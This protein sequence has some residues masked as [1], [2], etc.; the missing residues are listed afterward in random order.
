MHR[1]EE[2]SSG[3]VRQTTSIIAI[4]LVGGER[5]ERLVG[6]PALD[7]DHWETKLVQPVKQDRRHSPRLEYNPTATRR[8]RQFAGDRLR[9]RRRLALTN[10]RP[11]TVKNANMRLV[12][13]DIE[14]SEIVHVGSPLPN[15]RR[16]YRPL[17]KSSRPLPDVEKLGFSSRSQLS[18]PCSRYEK[19]LL[20]TR[21]TTAVATQ[22][23]SQP[24]H[25]LIQVQRSANAKRGHFSARGQ[26]RGFS[27]E[28]VDLTRSTCRQGMAA[29]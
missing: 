3:E 21:P 11:F 4:G 5:L 24:A 23:S 29:I 8:F 28:S 1:L 18:R 25:G 26:F 12:H 22:R 16:C 15:R 19:F 20:G 27:T 10:D 14:A 13:R 7:A 6:L 2:A 17:W 9:C